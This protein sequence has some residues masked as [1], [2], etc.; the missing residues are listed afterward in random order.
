M[1][2]CAWGKVL[3]RNISSASTDWPMQRLVASKRERSTRVFR[4]RSRVVYFTRGNS[5]WISSQGCTIILDLFKSET[6]I[7]KRLFPSKPALSRAPNPKGPRSTVD[8]Y[9]RYLYYSRLGCIYR[10]LYL[11]CL[12]LYRPHRMSQLLTARSEALTA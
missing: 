12:Q 5:Y 11:K 10:T 2:D 8:R 1:R 3:T 4:N 9:W 6:D 7:L